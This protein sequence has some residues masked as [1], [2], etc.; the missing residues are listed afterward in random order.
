VNPQKKTALKVSAG[1]DITVTKNDTIKLSG[2]FKSTADVELFSWY[3]IG[4]TSRQIRANTQQFQYITP[5]S[6]CTLSFIFMVRTVNDLIAE[7]T[8][9]AY[10]IQDTIPTVNAGQDQTVLV[11]L[12]V[13]LRA[14]YS[15]DSI[16]AMF[17]K[18]GSNNFIPSLPETSFIA[19]KDPLL[20]P[21][22]FKVITSDD[23]EAVDTVNINVISLDHLPVIVNAGNDTSA[24]AGSR[25]TLH[26]TYEGKNIT[27]TFWKIGSGPFIKSPPEITIE[28]PDT[29]M[30]LIC[31]FMVQDIKRK[32]AL[33]TAIV[34]VIDTN[35]I[36][37]Q[38]IN[39]L[40]ADAGD[41]Q[42]V[43]FDSTVQLKGTGKDLV[44]PNNAIVKFE[45]KYGNGLWIPSTDGM[46]VYNP[47]EIPGSIICSLRVT[48][49]DGQ[50]ATDFC[51]INVLSTIEHTYSKWEYSREIELN[52]TS[53][54]ADVSKDVL[55]F[56]VLIR[57]NPGN[58]SYL[59]QTMAGG[60]DIRFAKTDGTILSY[61]I[62]RWV[63]NAGDADTAEIWVKVDT[64]FGNNSTQ[65]FYMYWGKSGAADSSNP[66]AVFAAGNDFNAVWHLEENGS[67][68]SDAYKDATENS[69]DGTGVNL[70]SS[71]DVSGVIGICQDFERD[72]NDYITVDCAA[73]LSL[74][75][76]TVSAWTQLESAGRSRGILGTRFPDS[77][78]TFDFKWEA[79]KLHGDI[80]NGSDWL[81]TSADYLTTPSIGTWYH[82]AYVVTSN[83]YKIYLDGEEVVGSGSF[84]GTPLFMNSNVSLRIGYS[85]DYGIECMDGKIDEVR[86]S[87]TSRSADW[88]KL[89]Y[90]NQ[91]SGQTL[92][93]FGDIDSN[94]TVIH[95]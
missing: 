45:W 29:A 32:E 35:A 38:D 86:I 28:V 41:D 34:T 66:E 67:T 70:T 76:W 95:K 53:G 1:E 44:N 39:T 5:D 55:N 7:D 4:D 88:I 61:E 91:K 36:H 74:N 87:R 77:E 83:S 60:A 81:T 78:N 49:M 27:H 15:A 33:D 40:Q 85:S 72:N 2:I 22:I 79:D 12:P 84:S 23:R 52:T 16:I 50:T 80:G 51:I 30:S 62:E 8:V 54:G 65:K 26:G 25:M 89:C 57:L 21:C 69:N 47:P 68:A 48:A 94:T 3:I 9:I 20:L 92:F 31:I 58:F 13:V 10:V 37:A 71:S 43:A 6:A 64:V 14:T 24:V 90:E 56:P 17:W 42:Y 46:G 82:V 63:D 75:T 93:S 19:P 11:D 18:I 73:S 59:P